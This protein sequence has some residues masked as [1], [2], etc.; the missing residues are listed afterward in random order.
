MFYR[1][2]HKEPDVLI[3]VDPEVSISEQHQPKETVSMACCLRVSPETALPS[4]SESE[5][6]IC[7]APAEIYFD[8]EL[9]SL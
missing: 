5:A 3:H 6:T 1:N 7:L 2:Q 4:F 9:I 8:D